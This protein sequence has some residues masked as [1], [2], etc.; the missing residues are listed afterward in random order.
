M[1]LTICEKC[2]ATRPGYPTSP[3]RSIVLLASITIP[4]HKYPS[5]NERPSHN[6]TICCLVAVP[7]RASGA[8]THHASPYVGA[9]SQVALRS[10]GRPFIIFR[11]HV[12]PAWRSAQF[13]SPTG[14]PFRWSTDVPGRVS[15]RRPFTHLSAHC[16]TDPSPPTAQIAPE[17]AKTTNTTS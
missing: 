10:P 1:T 12:V 9:G 17:Q 16:F 7:F 5:S 14:G 13:R 15:P 2:Y 3:D 4:R 8:G 11:Q 6:S